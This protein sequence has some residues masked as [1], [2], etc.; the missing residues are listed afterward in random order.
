M[1]KEIIVIGGGISGLY[2]AK[3]L[4]NKGYKVSLYEKNNRLGGNIRT[5]YEE[6]A[7]LEQGAG[8][9]NI[10]HTR[11]L[12]LLK[13]YNLNI[14]TLSTDK[15]YKEV[16]CKKDKIKKTNYD[17]QIIKVIK[18][19]KTLD[20][21]SLNKI[22]FGQLCEQVLGIEDTKTVINSFGYNAE[23]MVSNAL[24]AITTF[25]KDFT[26]NITYYHCKE[27]L[28]ELIHR[29]ETDLISKGV[30][31][32]KEHSL[33]SITYK[34]KKF[35]L[36]IFDIDNSIN[37]TVKSK[38]LV[39]AIPQTALKY[40]DFFNKNNKDLFDSVE[41]ISLHR[42]YAKYKTN[43]VKDINRTTT[44][45]P[46]RQF[47]PVKSEKNVVMVSYSDLHDADYWK[48]YADLGKLELEKQLHK[49]L[50]QLFPNKRISKTEWLYSFYWKEG[51]HVWKPEI[52]P[53]KIRE[54]LKL[55]HPDLYIVGESFS[56]HQGWSEGAL[57]T[58]D[59][60]INDMDNKQIG[61]NNNYKEWIKSKKK[62]TSKDLEEAKKLY[63]DF[64]WVILK[65]PTDKE[66]RL[67]DVTEW[68]KY[69]PGGAGPFLNNKYKDISSIFVRIPYHYENNSLKETVIGKVK[70]YTITYL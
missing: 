21:D 30:N 33:E 1:M 29:M 9:F 46:I 47:I 54:S 53:Y 64:I 22:T 55:I 56:I 45:L 6:E 61:G 2:S 43:W 25:E 20:I 50:K 65:L 5:Q 59:E 36:N 13:E 38:E 17:K 40:L 14:E 10:N 26:P 3:K 66:K 16:L 69:H 60:M 49:Q 28:E 8:R 18:Y 15:Y 39:L 19:A 34:Y 31:I 52:D 41:P 48:N 37:K 51:V 67:I 23:F 58:V 63:P 32:Y 27:G 4:T 35:N 70:K 11:L 57:E 24:I 44:D 12:E 68:L 7:K 42:I 62:I